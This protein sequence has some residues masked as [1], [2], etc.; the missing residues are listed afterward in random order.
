ML[1]NDVEDLYDRVKV[2]TKV[3]I[4]P[5]PGGAQANAAGVAPAPVTTGSTPASTAQR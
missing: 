5:K 4:L 1:N 3:V 2:G